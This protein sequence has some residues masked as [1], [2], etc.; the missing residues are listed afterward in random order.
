MSANSQKVKGVYEI[1]Y[2]ISDMVNGVTLGSGAR[3]VSAFAST[4]IDGDWLLKSYL[5]PDHLPESSYLLISQNVQTIKRARLRTPGAEF[6]RAA[7]E[8]GE[9]YPI[10]ITIEACD[11]F[12]SYST[13]GDDMVCL[14][15][16]EFNKWEDVS[17]NYASKAVFE[18]GKDYFQ[19]RVTSDVPGVG[20]PARIFYDDYN[21]QAAYVGQSFGLY[22]DLEI[23]T[24]GI[25]GVNTGRVY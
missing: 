8:P 20:H 9:I 22:L 12:D 15:L 17:I 21:I 7:Y 16:T 1:S 6:L 19:F 24:A 14:N 3:S 13:I 4:Q 5:T 23:D 25:Y 10:Q 11:P 2:D 18:S